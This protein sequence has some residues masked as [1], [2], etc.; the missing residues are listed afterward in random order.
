L[1]LDQPHRDSFVQQLHSVGMPELVRGQARRTPAAIAGS[2]APWLVLVP[3]KNV[4]RR[5]PRFRNAMAVRRSS[6]SARRPFGFVTSSPSAAQRGV[7]AGSGPAAPTSVYAQVGARGRSSA[8]VLGEMQGRTQSAI[9]FG[10]V[11]VADL[12]GGCSMADRAC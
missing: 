4:I 3:S 7:P 12:A 6:A 1:A 8:L 2:E 9:P 5:D 10:L 11:F